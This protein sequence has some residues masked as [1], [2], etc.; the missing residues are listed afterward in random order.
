M[1]QSR[2]KKSKSF[3]PSTASPTHGRKGC[4]CKNGRTYS[5]KC[6]DGSVE[7]Q[8]IGKIQLKNLTV[9]KITITYL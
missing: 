6:C 4:L 8:G 1:A 3:I 9:N 5:R 2:N 7:A